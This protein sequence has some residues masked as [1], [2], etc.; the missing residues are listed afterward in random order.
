MSE[1]L[2]KR[3]GILKEL[4]KRLHKSANPEEIKEESQRLCD[5]HLAVFKERLE[6]ERVLV[7]EKSS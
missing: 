4:I 5:I 2:G 3:K 7:P 6:R 1:L